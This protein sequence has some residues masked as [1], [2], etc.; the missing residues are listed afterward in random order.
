MDCFGTYFTHVRTSNVTRVRSAT[1]RT[2]SECA[3]TK[4]CSGAPLRD[5]GPLFFNVFRL[6][7]NVSVIVHG[8]IF[9]VCCRLFV[10]LIGCLF[11][12]CVFLSVVF[13]CFCCVC[14]CFC[15][16]GCLFLC[17]FVRLFACLFASFFYL[18]NCVFVY[19]LVLVYLF[20]FIAY[21]FIF[22]FSVQCLTFVDACLFVCL[23][24][25]WDGWL[26][27]GC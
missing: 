19:Y 27:F 12:F 17:L 2:A 21:C 15:L 4:A 9:D 26:A 3:E 7:L 8:S 13:V 23:F 24:V 22:L 14:L 18:T 10:C 16:F 25:W 1:E 11:L 20:M 6:L 5:D